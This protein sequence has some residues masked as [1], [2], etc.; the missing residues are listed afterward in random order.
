MCGVID[1]GLL[2][3]SGAIDLGR[4][5]LPVCWGLIEVGL[6]A[7]LEL[8]RLLSREAHRQQREAMRVVS[9]AGISREPMPVF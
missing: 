5:L 2:H 1:L 3:M 7:E 8:Q 4:L 6:L 9:K